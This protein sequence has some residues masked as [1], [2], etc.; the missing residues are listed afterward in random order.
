MP[1][2]LLGNEGS[3]CGRDLRKCNLNL[4]YKMIRLAEISATG[5]NAAVGICSIGDYTYKAQPY[6]AVFMDFRK[7][8]AFAARAFVLVGQDDIPVST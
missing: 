2:G 7:T 1:A 5:G 6:R 4:E 3:N 8:T